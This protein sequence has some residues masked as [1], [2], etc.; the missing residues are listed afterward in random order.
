MF[1]ILLRLTEQDVPRPGLFAAIQLTLIFRQ[2]GVLGGGA[3]IVNTK[4]CS[5]YSSPVSCF[6]LGSVSLL[7]VNSPG[8]LMWFGRYNSRE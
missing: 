4:I 1:P 5:L 7:P 3:Q 8:R 6:R 2:V